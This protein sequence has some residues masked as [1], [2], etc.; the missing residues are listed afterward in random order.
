L[1]LARAARR[2]LGTAMQKK[3]NLAQAL[4]SFDDHWRPRIVGTVN[5]SK[6]QVVKFSGDFVWHQHDESDDFFLVLEG[7]LLIDLPDETV[8]LDPGEFLVVPAGVRHR[9]RAE[10]EVHVLNIEATGTL[11]T[12]DADHPGDLTAPEQHL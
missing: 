2:V 9:P 3:I 10:Q 12:G 4:A 6:I 5:S 11:N 8:T 7:R 1:D